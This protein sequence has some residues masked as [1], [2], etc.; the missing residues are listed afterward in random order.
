M[1]LQDLAKGLEIRSFKR[2]DYVFREKGFGSQEMFFIFSGEIHIQKTLGGIEEEINHLG[3]G[4]FFGEIALVQNVPRTASAL[5]VSDSAKVAVISRNHFIVLSKTN[6]EFLVVLFRKM[7][8][9]V[10]VREE[11]RDMLDIQ[12]QEID[13]MLAANMWVPSSEVTESQSSSESAAP[14]SSEDEAMESL[15]GGDSADLN[16]SDLGSDSSDD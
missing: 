5:V 1:N 3:P 4:S 13:A 9:R 10:L 14:S 11:M 8:E 2:G 16:D 7:Q 6:P 15:D 12:E